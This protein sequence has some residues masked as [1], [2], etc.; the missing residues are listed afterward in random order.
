M[1][2]LQPDRRGKEGE[3]MSLSFKSEFVNIST[4]DIFHCEK[5]FCALE[6]V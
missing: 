2:Q 5:I 1:S 3:I 4:I 6:E